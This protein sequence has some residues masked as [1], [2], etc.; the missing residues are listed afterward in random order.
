MDSRL[1]VNWNLH[2]LKDA[3]DHGLSHGNG[4]GQRMA[5]LFCCCLWTDD[6]IYHPLISPAGLGDLLGDRSWFRSQLGLWLPLLPG[7]PVN[8]M[9]GKG[10]HLSKC[11]FCPDQRGCPGNPKPWRNLASFS[12]NPT[13]SKCLLKHA[14]PQTLRRQSNFGQL[15]G[16][17]ANQST[18][19]FSALA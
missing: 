10:R 2:L 1:Q 6:R 4:V 16:G 13:S 3:V 11:A 17:F 8:A 14:L 12:P 5:F 9:A 7:G 18:V 19:Y 15:L